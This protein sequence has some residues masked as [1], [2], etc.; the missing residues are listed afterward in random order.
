MKG[1]FEMKQEKLVYENAKVEVTLLG[2]E[3]IVTASTADNFD[4]VDQDAWDS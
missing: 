3:D 2:A 4:F 1:I